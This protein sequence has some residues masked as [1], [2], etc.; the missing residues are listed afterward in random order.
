MSRVAISRD[1]L[2]WAV[3]R[4]GASPE[5]FEEKFPKIGQWLTGDS[6]PTL[7]QLESLARTTRTPLGFL[8]LTEPPEEQ[9]PIPYFR[10]HGEESRSRPSPEL[11][12]T[13]HVMQQRQAW[14]R[15][16][17]TEEAQERLSIV[18]FARPDE[19]ATSIA[20]SIR[21]ELGLDEGWA[22]AQRTWTDALRVLRDVM[23]SARI[24]VVFNGVVGNNTHRKLD[25]SEFR[26]FVLV[27]E[28]APL[29]FVNGADSKAAQMFTLAHE[30][31]HL[32]YGSSAAFDLREMLPA[33]DSTE[34]ACN[35]VAAEFLLPGHEVRQS[36][37]SARNADEPFQVLA[38]QFK[39]SVLVAA[40]RVLD[41]GLIPKTAFLEF[42]RAYPEDERR[43]AGDQPGRGD[44][45][46]NQNVRVGKRFAQA[47][48][49]AASEG[50]LL[51]SEAYRLT[52]LHGAAFSRYA[53]LLKAEG[54]R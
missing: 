49:R 14:M 46:A 20:N 8:F 47:V 4:S 35:R 12:D 29:V 52:G 15:E 17:L 11:F 28:Y 18:R 31:A 54:T 13:I 48:I 41:L 10:T 30:L 27:D 38:R 36:W 21:H 5:S 24:L 32:A 6:Q 39:V 34:Q 37:P 44:F 1:V 7:R 3:K 33:D 40:R 45:Y 42:Y 43:A 9:L 26:G 50:K 19:S 23:E 53:A 25:P 22:A 2:Q 16:Y 51:F